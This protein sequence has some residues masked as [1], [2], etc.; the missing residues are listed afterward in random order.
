MRSNGVIQRKF[1]LMDEQ[2]L[3]LSERI[4]DVSRETFVEDWGLRAM[5]ERALQVCVEIVID[6]AVDG[7]G[8]GGR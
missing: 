5:T 8:S 4:A 7:D 1:A 2:L 3:R 6:A